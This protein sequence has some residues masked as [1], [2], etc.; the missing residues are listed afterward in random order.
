MLSFAVSAQ[1]VKEMKPTKI[2]PLDF[3]KEGEAKADAYEAA[4]AKVSQKVEKKAALTAAEQKLY[5]E[6]DELSPGYW[7]TEGGGCSWYCGGEINEV[8]ASSSLK[9]QGAN[10]YEPKNAHDFSFKNAWVEGV[11]GYGVGEYLLYKFPGTC[12]RITDII[13][14]NG[15]VKSQQAYLDNSRVKK[16]KVYFNDKPIAILNLEDKRSK[17]IFN[18]DPIGNSNRDDAN[19]MKQRPWSLKFEI[20]EVY[21]GTKYDDVV[22]S[23]IFFDGIDVH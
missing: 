3:S 14:A 8:S 21:K 11:N 1:T 18:F 17:Q 23:E 9:S 16:L 19:I 2:L 12:P 22:I 7:D 6:Y 10:N 15:Y 4:Y 5:D 13:I 20:L